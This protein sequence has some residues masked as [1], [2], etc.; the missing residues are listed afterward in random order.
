MAELNGSFALPG[1]LALRFVRPE[2]EVFLLQLFI[3]ARPWLS[4]IDGNSDFLQSLYEQ[5]FD[6]LRSGLGGAYPEHMDM[7]IE[8]C[9]S[10]VGRLVVS[11]GYTSW[12]LS[13]LQILTAV[14][15][16][17]IGSSVLRAIQAAAQKVSLPIY[18][19]TP[20]FGGNTKRIYE[21]LGFRV[22]IA[23]PPHF[24]MQWLPSQVVSSV[25]HQA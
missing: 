15:G 18:L 8:D 5:Q 19:S 25:Q 1:N 10:R 4:W 13:E 20:M 6:A 21:R 14:R 24:H 7:I 9:G 12:R 11:L 17:G 2:D 23:D 3:E 16:K 22:T